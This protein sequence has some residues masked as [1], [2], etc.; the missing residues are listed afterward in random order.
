MRTADIDLTHHFD[1]VYRDDLLKGRLFI[2][3]WGRGNVK[4]NGYSVW[5]FSTAQ[6]A[7]SRRE[8]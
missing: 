1:H 5:F 2:Y 8:Q 7:E 3:L 4:L 6:S